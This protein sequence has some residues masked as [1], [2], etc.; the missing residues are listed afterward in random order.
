MRPGAP[1][2]IASAPMRV[3]LAGGGTDL[4]SYAERFGGAVISLAIDLRVVVA[5]SPQGGSDLLSRLGAG[6]PIGHDE[7]MRDQLAPAA[8]RRTGSHVGRLACVSAAPP[9]SG[10]GG[11]GAF[12]VA[13]VHALRASRPPAPRAIAEEASAIE[14]EDVGRSVGKQ[15][16]YLAALGGLRALRIDRDG[17]VTDES[18]GLGDRLAAYVAERL[19]LFHTGVRHDAG[20]IL[21]AQDEQTRRADGAT[22]A[23]L[24]AIH[25][26]V[27]PMLDA[28]RGERLEEIGPILS[29]HWRHKSGLSAA[30]APPRVANLHE[31]ALRSGADGG[32]LIGAG[33]GG[34]ILLSSRPRCQTRLRA[35]MRA[36][37][38][39]ELRFAASPTGTVLRRAP[40]AG[41]SPALAVGGSA[42]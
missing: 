12:L 18:V 25:A 3:S 4:P 20:A 13:L 24:K 14:M 42:P 34:C 41:H 11:S 9:G 31:L 29:E 21:A 35:A 27:E 30:V 39:T 37:G 1:L 23:R 32:K 2:A 26:L 28:I 40:L 33:G 19:L 38:A 17:L 16:H 5:A 15:D 6:T 7:L 36:A 8:I 10:L 22:L